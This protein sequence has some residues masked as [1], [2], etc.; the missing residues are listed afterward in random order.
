MDLVNVLAGSFWRGCTPSDRAAR[1][2]WK[3]VHPV[4]ISSSFSMSRFPVTQGLYVQIMGENPS[5]QKGEDLPVT[6][7]SFFDAALFCNESS[8]RSGLQPAYRIDGDRLEWNTSAAGYR[9]PTEAEWELAARGVGGRKYP[10]GAKARLR[11][12]CWNGD[13]NT[14]GKG[15]RKGPDE[16]WRHPRGATPEGIMAL[17]GHVWEWTFD[18]FA[19]YPHSPTPVPL[20]DPTGPAVSN[21]GDHPLVIRGKTYRVLRGA[22]WN[23]Q[24]TKWLV[25][26]A[27]C[28]EEEHARDR[29]RDR[30]VR[31]GDYGEVG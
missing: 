1:P 13:G 27:R 14:F 7:V 23:I 24:D 8:I 15:N 26:A 4:T 22:A 16:V 10:W 18:R 11:D 2:Q 17:V 28:P 29:H 6:N 12:I 9:L 30:V 20:V 31:G 21:P 5:S 25:A 19:P 3:P